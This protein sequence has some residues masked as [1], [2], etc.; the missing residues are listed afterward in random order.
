M[1]RPVDGRW[2]EDGV[3]SP[4]IRRR[5]EVGD[6]DEARSYS[7]ERTVHTFDERHSRRR[8]HEVLGRL[9]IE[10]STRKERYIR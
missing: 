4:V 1:A 2:L 9:P 3:V 6:E 7:S 5:A 10:A 8:E